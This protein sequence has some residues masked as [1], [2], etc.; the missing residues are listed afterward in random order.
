MICKTTRQ[1]T[2]AHFVSAS[3]ESITAE[4][5]AKQSVASQSSLG[6]K[7]YT[8]PKTALTAA[9]LVQI[10]EI[11][12]KTPVIHGVKS[13][14]PNP[15][16]PIY[17]ENDKKI[18]VPRFY[19]EA[20]FGPAAENRLAP[21]DDIHVPFS[22]T[23]TLFPHQIQAT[24]AYLATVHKSDPPQGGGILELACGMGKTVIALNLIGRLQK[25]TLILVH[26]EFL[27]NQWIERIEEFL[28]TARIGKI[29]GPLRDIADKDIVLGMIQSMYNRDFPPDTFTSFGMTI[30]DEVHRIGSC[31]FSNT[32]CKVLTPMVLGISATVERKDGLTDVL[33]SFIGP[34][35]FSTGRTTSE[36]VV[37]VQAHRFHTQDPEFR[38]V[39]YDFRG[40]V[41]FSTMMSKLCSYAP[42]TDFLQQ[43]IEEVHRKRPTSQMIVLA[44]NRCLLVDLYKRLTPSCR[45]S[46]VGYYLGG[47]KQAALQASE[48]CQIVLATYAMAAEA[49]DI[50]SLEILVLATPKT[51]IVQSVGRIL[52]TKHSQPLIIDIVDLHDTFQNQWRKRKA[53][54]RKC[55][56][57]ILDEKGKGKATACVE[58]EDDEV[59]GLEGMELGAFK[60]EEEE[61]EI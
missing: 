21:G 41:K 8:I 34:K 59:V 24:D 35:I 22:S 43:R 27:M 32:L 7:G 61:E 16:F 1:K 45:G 42:R 48:S 46:T 5:E 25:K 36:Q 57:R 2:E 55:G 15:G 30:I 28:P 33:Y 12:F 50:K 53:Y 23:K 20:R 56:Y 18:Y 58:E 29:Q 6:P 44:H 26:K 31:E 51:D 19:G 49:L 17:R 10:K 13:A 4:T 37:E 40:Q 11:L 38:E 3:S 9:E 52:R 39:E 54:Y 47:M 14:Q 60:R